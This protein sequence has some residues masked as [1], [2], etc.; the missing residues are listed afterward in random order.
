MRDE[1]RPLN[2]SEV[3]AA[4][5]DISEDTLKRLIAAGFFPD[6]IFVTERTSHWLWKDIESYRYLRGRC[7]KFPKLPTSSE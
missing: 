6:A 5:G 7:G 3:R 4:L 2:S 1:D